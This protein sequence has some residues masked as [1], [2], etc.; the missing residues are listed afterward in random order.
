M[1]PRERPAE[2]GPTVVLS[3]HI[4]SLAGVLVDHPLSDNLDPCEVLLYHEEKYWDRASAAVLQQPLDLDY[5]KTLVAV[6]QMVGATDQKEA[7]A[8]IRTAWAAHYGSGPTAPP[9]T[10]DGLSA[11]R[12]FLTTVY[13]P[14][15]HT[16]WGGIGPDVLTAKL[17]N[18]VEEDI[19]DAGNGTFITRVLPH[20]HLSPAQRRHCLA[21][22]GRCI[23]SHPALAIAAAQ[24]VA[25][26]PHLLREDAQDLLGKLPGPTRDIWRTAMSDAR[27]DH[28]TAVTGPAAGAVPAVRSDLPETSLAEPDSISISPVQGPPAAPHPPGSDLTPLLL[29][30]SQPRPAPPPPKAGTPGTAPATPHL[31]PENPTTRTT[32]LPRANPK[33]KATHFPRRTVP[34]AVRD[35]YGL[36]AQGWRQVLATFLIIGIGLGMAFWL[37]R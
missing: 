37:T 29:V 33:G 5:R 16:Y 12:R 36:D 26:S 19:A 13:P 32:P 8:A 21:I 6:Q 17:I 23:S 27:H 14:A 9:L 35:Y 4:E 20:A 3:V 15:G 22:M 2:D 10:A 18:D 31:Q 7:D 28:D 30:P 25:S 1:P 24:A 34:I 11:Q